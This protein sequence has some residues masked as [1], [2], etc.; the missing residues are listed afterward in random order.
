MGTDQNEKAVS[1][2]NLLLWGSM[3]MQ[4]GAL[5]AIFIGLL[6][7]GSKHHWGIWFSIG[8]WTAFASGFIVRSCA[9]TWFDRR[10]P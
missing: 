2:M 5:V 9:R 10:G 3:V 8:G 7:R 6:A 4:L 1:R